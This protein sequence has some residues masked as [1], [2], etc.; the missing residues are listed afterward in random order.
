[1]GDKDNPNEV[2]GTWKRINTTYFDTLADC[3]HVYTYGVDVLKQFNDNGGKVQK[4]KFLLHNDTDD[5]YIITEQ[6]DGVYYAKGFAS[7]KAD[8]TTFAPNSNG[9]VIVKELED[10]TYSLTET[11]TEKG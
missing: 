7:K 3:C 5:C 4:V 1:M 2:E 11:A 6:K 10:D 8:A 9:H